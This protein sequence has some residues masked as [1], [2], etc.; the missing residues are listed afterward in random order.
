MPPT[1]AATANPSGPT[2]G[3]IAREPNGTRARPFAS[4]GLR[5]TVFDSGVAADAPPP[6]ATD[7]LRHDWLPPP[8]VEVTADLGRLGEPDTL[9][10]CVPTALT[11]ARGAD[12]TALAA[13]ARAISRRLRAGQLVVL[14]SPAPPGTA[15]AVVLPLLAATG[16]VPGRDF[17]LACAVPQAE[18]AALVV[19]GWDGAS[20]RAAAALYTRA[21][22]VVSCVSSL[23]AAEVC[24]TIG[25]RS[26]RFGRRWRTS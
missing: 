1:D 8:G 25:G 7:P 6:P 15:R 12:T 9:L 20:A 23:E 3:L 21:G 11:S 22:F 16:L 19:G 10:V 14:T 2:V 13:V 26:A 4:V 5:V 24:G 17:F 18:H